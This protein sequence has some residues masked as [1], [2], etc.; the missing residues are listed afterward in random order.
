MR[1]VFIC[2]EPTSA[3]DEKNAEN[4]MENIISEPDRT[5]ICVSQKKIFSKYFNKTINIK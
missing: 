1:D 5:V 4:I 2:D 3:L